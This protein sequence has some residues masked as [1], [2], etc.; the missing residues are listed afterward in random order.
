M[1]EW[2]SYRLSSF[3]LFSERTYRR[4]FELYNAEVWPAQL[5]AL[6]LGAALLVLALARPAGAARAAFAILGACW[7]WVAAAFLARHYATI[8]WAAPWLAVA[9][10]AQG[11]L[12]LGA[13][14]GAGGVRLHDPRGARGGIGLGLLLAALLAQPAFAPLA[15]RP[16]QAAE[17]FG[18]A[19]DPTVAGTLG[20][21]AL[22]QVGGAHGAGVAPR[23]LVCLLWPIPLAAALASGLLFAAMGSPQALWLPLAALLA[24]GSTCR[25]RRSRT[26]R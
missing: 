2:W 10:G 19:P 16:W 6:G 23:V 7:L 24:L 22:V 3:L 11:A 18:L 1:S 17:V 5:A 14:A 4:L 13:A 15:G 12:L 25:G 20:V 9:F 8:N 21:L 26:C